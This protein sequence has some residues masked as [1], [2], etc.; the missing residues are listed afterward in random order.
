MRYKFIWNG[1]VL[2]DTEIQIVRL[3][4]FPTVGVMFPKSMEQA[5]KEIMEAQ[6]FRQLSY[7][8]RGKMGQNLIR[9][10]ENPVIN[11]DLNEKRFIAGVGLMIHVP[12]GVNTVYTFV[13]TPGRQKNEFNTWEL[14]QDRNPRMNTEGC[15]YSPGMWFKTPTK[16]GGES[17]LC[18]INQN[19]YL[20]EADLETTL[21]PTTPSR[22][23]T[24]ETIHA[25]D[26]LQC[27]NLSGL[28][29]ELNVQEMANRIIFEINPE[30]KLSLFYGSMFHD[31]PT[32]IAIQRHSV[33]IHTSILDYEQYFKF[34]GYLRGMGIIKNTDILGKKQFD[35]I[36]AIKYSKEKIKL[37]DT[38]SEKEEAYARWENACEESGMAVK[39]DSS[40]EK[41]L[42]F[43][44]LSK[45]NQKSL[46]IEEVAKKIGIDSK[47]IKNTEDNIKGITKQ[48]EESQLPTNP[49]SENVHTPSETSDVRKLNERCD[50]L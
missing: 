28:Q 14:Q 31:I 18:A 45:E 42:K 35:A 44:Y 11:F 41:N 25:A 24:H 49:I 1:K 10:L 22:L 39:Y 26:F 8:K 23:F 46:N 38:V 17:Q 16:P 43:M 2:D 33:K 3:K 6:V 5:Q 4:D 29:N 34:R 12:K 15:T 27:R 21:V 30:S 32:E 36:S 50:I 47:D 9:E 20:L 7:L 37:Y 48:A 13:N 19:D 40:D